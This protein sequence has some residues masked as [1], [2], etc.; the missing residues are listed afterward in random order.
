LCFTAENQGILSSLFSAC[1]LEFPVYNSQA[2]WFICSLRVWAPIHVLSFALIFYRFVEAVQVL[3]SPVGLGIIDLGTI[4]LVCFCGE[5]GT[6]AENILTKIWG[7]HSPP[8]WS[9]FPVLQV[10]CIALLTKGEKNFSGGSGT[11]FHGFTLVYIRWRSEAASFLI[12][13]FGTCYV[14]PRGRHALNCLCISEK[15]QYSIENQCFKRKNG[16][17]VQSVFYFVNKRDRYC[18]CDLWTYSAHLLRLNCQKN[19]G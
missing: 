2:C 11:A 18:T 14:R 15:H 3:S 6:A 8:L 19:F 1:S 13:F 10:N 7:S 17:S 4:V 16:K 12:E 9:P 5:F